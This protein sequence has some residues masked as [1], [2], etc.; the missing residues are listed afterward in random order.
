M[1]SSLQRCQRW[2]QDVVVGLDLC[3]WAAEPLQSGSLRWRAVDT[4]DVAELVAEVLFEAQ[5]MAGSEAVQTTLLVL[6]H[7]HAT[8]KF[9][10]LLDLVGLAEA[11]LDDFGLGDQVQLVAF[12]P[13]FQYADADAADP[14]NGT[15]RSPAPMV[16][17]LRR[18]ELAQ[19]AVDGV[20]LSERNARL[21]RDRARC[22]EM[23][24]T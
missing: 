22:P 13:Q 20:A 11:V 4:V 16:H 2:V 12:H 19:L 10:D 23:M 1:S 3:P 7:P 5:V 9:L 18:A 8:P 17:L 15:N 24:E 14:A 6:A 21:L